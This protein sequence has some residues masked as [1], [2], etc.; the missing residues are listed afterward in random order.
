M[1]SRGNLSND[2]WAV[3]EP[4]PHQG[5]NN[6]CGRWRDAR[7]VINGIIH[8]L[9]TGCHW[10]ELPERFGPWQTLEEAAPARPG[11]RRRHGR[12]RLE[13]QHRLHLDPRPPARR[14]GPMKTRR[15]QRPVLRKGP[16]KDQFTLQVH[17][18]PRPFPAGAVLQAKPSAAR[19]AG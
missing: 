8:R 11:R 9:G 12:H 3:L 14:R 1:L 16:R 19:S 5:N 18:R 17:M 15:R 10:R 6:R 4:L 13:Y 7:Q 2:E